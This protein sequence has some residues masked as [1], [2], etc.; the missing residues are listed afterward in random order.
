MPYRMLIGVYKRVSARKTW[1]NIKIG[2]ISLQCSLL[3]KLKVCVYF[4]LPLLP[5]STMSDHSLS[6]TANTA[7]TKCLT[8]KHIE[9]ATATELGEHKHYAK[10]DNPATLYP[11][12]ASD[13]G[14][15]D[16]S[17]H[18]HGSVEERYEKP[19]TAPTPEPCSKKGASYSVSDD[20]AILLQTSH[21]APYSGGGNA[22]GGGLSLTYPSPAS[23]S[24]PRAWPKVHAETSCTF[25][26]QTIP[27]HSFFTH[28]PHIST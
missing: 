28:S 6:S 4:M 18:P 19:R 20:A 2:G 5:K 23:S 22:C 3:F 27:D 1:P 11:T 9:D 7:S 8:Q 21:T 16:P 24:S 14:Q 12:H 26:L 10:S 17:L 15:V 13:T 25:S